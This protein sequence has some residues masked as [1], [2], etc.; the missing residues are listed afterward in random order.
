MRIDDFAKMLKIAGKTNLPDYFRI[1]A[2]R[3]RITPITEHPTNSPNETR[4]EEKE[5]QIELSALLQVSTALVGSTLEFLL[6]VDPDSAA[7]VSGCFRD[8]L[9]F[10]KNCVLPILKHCA[11][12]IFFIL[13]DS[14][15]HS[16]LDNELESFLTSLLQQT[17][18]RNS[19]VLVI[20]LFDLGLRVSTM[21]NQNR[22]DIIWRKE[23]FWFGSNIREQAKDHANY[24]KQCELNQRLHEAIIFVSRPKTA[25]DV[26]EFVKK[27]M[28]HIQCAEALFIEATNL[29]DSEWS[30]AGEGNYHC[31]S[32]HA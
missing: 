30:E 11:N 6:D 25:L 14:T 7:S 5:E 9:L 19:S 20:K 24:A 29:G 1:V 3:I 27:V 32:T 22:Q 15:K 8:S 2:V 18:I 28:E 21:L 16:Q 12:Y 31:G 13:F 17:S 4:T 26:I 23:N 10:T